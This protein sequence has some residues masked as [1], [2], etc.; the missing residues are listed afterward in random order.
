MPDILTTPPVSPSPDQPAAVTADGAN[1]LVAL[2]SS[3]MPSGY[4][5]V[6]EPVGGAWV[7]QDII[8]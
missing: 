8:N 6:A 5:G 4:L 7:E 1:L 2:S 3:V